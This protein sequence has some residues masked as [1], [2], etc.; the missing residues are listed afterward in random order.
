MSAGSENERDAKLAKPNGNWPYAFTFEI[1]VKNGDVE[2]ATFDPVKRLAYTLAR[3]RN[4]VAQ[5][6]DKI[7]EHH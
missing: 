7:L 2:P 6:I 5:G 3:S 1:H 4:R